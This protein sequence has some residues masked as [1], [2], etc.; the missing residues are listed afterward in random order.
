MT[1]YICWNEPDDD[2]P[3]NEP[4][5]NKLVRIKWDDAMERVKQFHPNFNRGSSDKEIW[6]FYQIVYWAWIEEVEDDKTS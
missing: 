3:I 5:T 4:P 2:T 6:E 1:K